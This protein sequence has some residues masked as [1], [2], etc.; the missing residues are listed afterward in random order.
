M[1][2]VHQITDSEIKDL[3]SVDGRSLAEIAMAICGYSSDLS[4]SQ[5]GGKK[6]EY[7]DKVYNRQIEMLCF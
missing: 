3:V 1:S 5:F 2:Q 7:L 6:D 4:P